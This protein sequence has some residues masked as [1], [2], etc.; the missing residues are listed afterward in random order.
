MVSVTP[1]R[2]RTG[3]RIGPGWIVV[4][5][6]I[7]LLP[8]CAQV[9]AVRPGPMPDSGIPGLSVRPVAEDQDLPLQLLDGQFKLQGGDIKGGAHAY[10]RAAALSQDPAL[11]EQATQLA[12]AAGEWDLARLAADRWQVLAP[13]S[14]GVLQARAWIALGSGQDEAAQA[15]FVRL[16]DTGGDQAWRLLGQ[17]LLGAPDK[18]KAAAVLSRLAT[19]QRLGNQAVTWL[20][21]S[22]LAFKLG[23]KRTAQDLSDQ[24][25]MRFHDV[26]SYAWNAFL[27]VD[28][29]DKAMARDIYAE[30]LRHQ[31]SSPRL[32]TG[33][34]SL[35]ADLGDER[36]AAKTLA[37]GVQDDLTYTARMTYAARAED[38][39]AL[40]ALY[41][42]VR[43]DKAAHTPLRLYLL[44]QLAELND[45]YPGALGW[46]REVPLDDER[47]FDAQLRQAVVLDQSGQVD[48]ALEFVRRL[49]SES[50]LEND[51]VAKLF[52]L[53]ADLLKRHQR[54]AEARA[55]YDRALSF[56][57]EDTR[58]LY[59]RAL[60]AASTGDVAVAEADLRRVIAQKPD[61][62]AALNALGYTLA[63]RTDRLDEALQLIEQAY[64]LQPDEASIIDSLGWVQFRLGR[65]AEA[66]VTLKKAYEMFAD[67][68]VAAHY[69]EALWVSGNRELALKVLADARG[70]EPDSAIL[71]ETQQRLKP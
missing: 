23:D 1:A 25:V 33:Y 68:E 58:L 47:W 30:G 13:S 49:Q 56:L 45:D 36:G 42:E 16:V 11:A 44:G 40:A 55:V 38:K 18:G 67:P 2:N 9:P 8:G 3:A 31:P 35:L 50:G 64:Q 63:D 69:A 37:G 29:G 32:R 52:L 28:L 62:A 39:A 66:V 14:P 7:T 19:P 4:L 71:R 6:L 60:V 26:E 21:M 5:G 48:E 10:V 65:H 22:Q 54:N 43:A 34:A 46:Y 59:S 12:L 15:A 53:E 24:A 70:K 61:D 51:A 20:A 27:A 41:R 57:P 17:A